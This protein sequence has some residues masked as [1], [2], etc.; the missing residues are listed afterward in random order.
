MSNSIPWDDLK[1]GKPVPPIKVQGSDGY[2]IKKNK[3]L[4]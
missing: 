4:E 1:N 3:D 2:G